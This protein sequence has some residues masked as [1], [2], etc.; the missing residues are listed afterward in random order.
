MKGVGFSKRIRVFGKYHQS[1]SPNISKSVLHFL[2]RDMLFC[3]SLFFLLPFDKS[4]S[5]V[6]K[7]GHPGPSSHRF[8]AVGE[9][10][11]PPRVGD[12]VRAALGGARCGVCGEAPTGGSGA[13]T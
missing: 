8:D 13:V 10:E 9:S 12:Q 7:S 6:G 11:G 1:Q 2:F 3:L 4:M 5:K